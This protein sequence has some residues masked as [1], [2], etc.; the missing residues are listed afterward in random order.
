MGHVE[1]ELE[2][3]EVIQIVEERRNAYRKL[4]VRGERLMGA[5][6]VG[7]T[8]SAA[9]LV[10]LFDRDE[11]LPADP[12]EVLC[13]P[14]AAGAPADR[15]ICNCNKVTEAAVKAAVA[16]GAHSVA[17]IGECTRAGTGCG[18]CKAELGEILARERKV[19]LPLLA[20]G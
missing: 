10:Q 19:V 7:H 6:L 5:M 12:L 20:A 14:V 11:P 3:D 13:Q 17:A 1:P 9:A 18:S 2:T 16:S 8:A 15:V 4:I